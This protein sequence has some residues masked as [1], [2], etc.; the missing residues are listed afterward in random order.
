MPPSLL[1]V[2]HSL[3][4]LYYEVDFK[5]RAGFSNPEIEALVLEGL[6]TLDHK[7]RVAIYHEI[8]QKL[9]EASPILFLFVRPQRFEFWR[10]YVKGY[11]PTP[12]TSRIHFKQT[13]IDKQ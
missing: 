7:K 9:A 1:G 8:E 10:D 12:Q 3:Y 6:K 5:K 13:W 11:I 4:F 2:I